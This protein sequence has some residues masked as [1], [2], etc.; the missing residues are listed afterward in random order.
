MRTFHRLASAVP[1]PQTTLGG[2]LARQ[3]HSPAVQPAPPTPRDSNGRAPNGGRARAGELVGEALHVLERALR[4]TPARGG[5]HSLRG[6]LLDAPEVA[7]QGEALE[8]FR[9]A[10]RIGCRRRV[11]G[12]PLPRH[13]GATFIGSHERKE[14]QMLLV[15]PLAPLSG[16]LALPPEPALQGRRPV[17]DS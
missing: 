7:R 5:V 12:S 9:L 6:I 4:L 1:A 8:S 16:E 10:S 3:A 14:V 17:C 11:C 13:V 2:A 15:P